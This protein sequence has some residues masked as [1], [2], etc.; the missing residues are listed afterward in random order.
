MPL[1]LVFELIALYW[2]IGHEIISRQE[3]EGWVTA[4]IERLATDLQKSFPGV[5]GF[6]ARNI[7]R[8]RAF[9]LAYTQDIKGSLDIVVG[10]DAQNLPQAVA[11]IPWGHNVLVL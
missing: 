2:D 5:K 6:S 1:K 7:W 8:I 9:Y 3:S 4:V 10:V 11:E